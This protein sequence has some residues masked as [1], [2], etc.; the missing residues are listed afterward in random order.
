[1]ITRDEKSTQQSKP[2]SPSMPRVYVRE[3]R[4]GDNVNEIFLL[5]DRQLRANRNANLYFLATLR[6]RTGV[7]SGL[8]WNVTEDAVKDV[9]AGDF[10]RVK[11]KV[12][13]YQGNLQLILTS[14]QSVSDSACDPADFQIQ[15]QAAAGRFLI[16]LR[17][18]LESIRHPDLAAVAYAF[19]GNSSLVNGLCGAPAGVKAHHA[20]IGGLIEHVVSMCELAD[21]I[22]PL[23]PRWIANCCFWESCCTTSARFVNWPR[24]RPSS[25]PT[26]GSCSGTS[27][28]EMK[29]FQ[30]WSAALNNSLDDRSK[31]KNF[32]DCGT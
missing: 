20:Y 12:Q 30:N 11:G 19:L 32:C 14:V 7:I 24:T 8:M 1:V 13:Q 23:Y 25:T 5:A 2:E 10:V 9:S 15:P 28:S 21:R 4:D 17:E 3:L 31:P 16:R 22:A 29:S 18:L 6:D 26:K 27:I